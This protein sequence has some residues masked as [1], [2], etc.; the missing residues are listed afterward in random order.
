MQGMLEQSEVEAVLQKFGKYLV[1][2]SRSNLTRKDKNVRKNLYN[3]LSY[4]VA[5]G[6][7]SFSFSFEM[8]D[9]G[10]FQDKGVRGAV[11]ADKAPNSPYRFG[12]GTGKPGGLSRGIEQWVKDKGFQFRDR[13]TGR[14]LSFEQT[15]KAIT[16]SVYMK[17]IEASR[18]YSRPFELGFEKLP[19]ELVEA[20]GLD[21]EKFL[22]FS[23]EKK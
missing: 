5:T 15:A 14:F 17:G 11:S 4:S 12:S 6:K 9:Y 2:Q 1:T 21:V 22:K 7:R 18:F 13:A 23:I 3:S 20:Y 19:D 16:R 10:K 8:E